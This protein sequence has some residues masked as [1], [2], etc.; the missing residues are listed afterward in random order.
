M[1]RYKRLLAVF[2]VVCFV[3]CSSSSF[4]ASAVDEPTTNEINAFSDELEINGK[5]YKV[6]DYNPNSPMLASFP[7]YD[8]DDVVFRLVSFKNIN[9]GYSKVFSLNADITHGV[10]NLLDPIEIQVQYQLPEEIAKGEI[11]DIRFRASSQFT[12]LDSSFT[13]YV[14][15]QDS[16]WDHFTQYN[17]SF[18]KNASDSDIRIEWNEITLKYPAK[19]LGFRFPVKFTSY[20]FIFDVTSVSFSPVSSNGM[21]SSIIDYLKNMWQSIKEIPEKISASISALGKQIGGFFDKLGAQ[22]GGYFDKMT[23]SVKG[24]FTEL[25]DKIGGYFTRL[26]NQIYW[27]NAEG[28]AE[29]QPPDI[30]TKFDDVTKSLNEWLEKLKGFSDSIES[31]GDEVAG[32]IKNGSNFIDRVLDVA[33]APVM[34]FLSFAVIFVVVRK[35]VGR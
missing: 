27:G 3:F 19:Y 4:V 26:W 8:L 14:Y 22:I 23:N 10:V 5:T 13:P 6:V 30:S 35:V 29:Y 18:S 15:F 24:F 9:T 11:Y 16:S 33:P 31:E 32:Y 17:G 2:L 7:N 12:K 21:L 20:H 1:K 34:V 28:E 25:G